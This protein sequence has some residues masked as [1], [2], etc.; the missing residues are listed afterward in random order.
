MGIESFSYRFLDI[1]GGPDLL[2]GEPLSQRPRDNMND[3]R[4]V[5]LARINPNK[6]YFIYDPRIP[7]ELASDLQQQFPNLQ[8]VIGKTNVE[9]TLYFLPFHEETFDSIEMN[10]VFTPLLGLDVF[11]NFPPEDAPLYLHTLAEAAR[12]L[13]SEGLLTIREKR[14]NMDPIINIIRSKGLGRKFYDNFDLYLI[15]RYRMEGSFPAFQLKEPVSLY[16]KSSLTAAE[17]DPRLQPFY[18]NFRKVPV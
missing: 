18:M 6:Q 5:N 9:P 14:I 3:L 2:P 13:K 17:G 4:A 7:T 11:K 8:F 10:F 12:V 1:G 16:A 15:D